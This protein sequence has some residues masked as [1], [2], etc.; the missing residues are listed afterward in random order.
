MNKLKKEI[1]LNGI[2]LLSAVLIC[3]III[4]F[5]GENPFDV[6]LVFLGGT[7]GSVT[8]FL[9]TLYYT[10]PLIFTGLAVGLGFR[11]GLF[12]IGAE[13]QLYAGSFAAA[14]IGFTLT[15]LPGWLLLPAAV[16]AAA[17]AGG[18][19]GWI[20]G[21]LKGRF[22]SHEVITTIM[23]NFIA[24]GILGY[25]ITKPYRDPAD[26]IPQ[27]VEISG[28]AKI[29]LIADVLK[30]IGIDLPQ[31]VP[32]NLSFLIAIAAAV[33]IW[34]LLWKTVPGYEIR[35][36]GMS[37]AAAA[38]SGINIVKVTALTMA[39]CGALAGF[40]GLNEVLGYRHRFLLNF[41]PGYGFTGI[42][43]ALMGRNHPFGIL[44]AAFLFGALTRG[45]IIIDI[46]FTN[47]SKDIIYIFQGI[48][49]LLIAGRN[50]KKLFGSK[51]K[52]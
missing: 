3:G 33:F 46:T 8:G 40:V 47:I 7:F 32:L 45:S 18:I 25:L 20:P 17:A 23:M 2:A 28:G 31:T 34:F 42:A 41:S 1:L 38:V 10:T 16:L 4:F 26:I 21:Y 12:N 51:F 36:V 50:Y 29:P 9:Y 30:Y 52:T 37:P 13:G 14:W 49:I 27:T 15:F 6:F 43:I 19:W 35:A 44:A 48:I 39:V 24:A 22:G 11:A 5:V